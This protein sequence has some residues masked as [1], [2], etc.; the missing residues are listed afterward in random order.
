MDKASF[1]PSCQLSGLPSP[2]WGQQVP[3]RAKWIVRSGDEVDAGVNGNCCNEAA[4]PDARRMTSF[5]RQ[6]TE[7]D[8]NDEQRQLQ[9]EPAVAVDSRR[10]DREQE[11]SGGQ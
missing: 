5:E 10:Q 4:A 6:R 7:A 11:H 8:V 9:P 2:Q 3:H 1:T